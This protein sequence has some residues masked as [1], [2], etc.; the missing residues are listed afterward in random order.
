M[1]PGRATGHLPRCRLPPVE[2]ET[3]KL[4]SQL[5]DFVMACCQAPAVLKTRPA[6]SL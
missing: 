1:K 2:W 5:G 6:L 3:L 4:S